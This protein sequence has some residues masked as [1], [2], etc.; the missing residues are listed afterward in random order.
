M[1]GRRLHIVVGGRTSKGHKKPLMLFVH[2]FPELW[3]TWWRQMQVRRRLPSGQS[4]R[5]PQHG[6]HACAPSRC[7]A[8]PDQRLPWRGAVTPINEQIRARLAAPLA[9]RGRSL[10]GLCDV[11]S[12]PGDVSALILH[13]PG[14]TR[15]LSALVTSRVLD[16]DRSIGIT[17]S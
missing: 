1:L 15:P 16:M 6:W 14:G 12:L 3:D 17:S 9:K 7:H 10:P 13:G 8:E 5:P 2:G 4:K 11:P